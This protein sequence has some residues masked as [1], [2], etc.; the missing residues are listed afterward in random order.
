MIRGKDP[1]SQQHRNNSIK[2]WEQIHRDNARE[3]IRTDDWL[4]DFDEI[5]LK[6]ERPILDLGCGSGND[7]LY[8]LNKGKQVIACDQSENAIGCIRRDFPEITEARCFNMLDGLPFENESF[9]IVIA[10]LCLHYFGG[11]DTLFVISEIGRI[12][13]PGGHLFL[14]VNSVNDKNHG[15]GRGKEIER[16]VYETEAGTIKRFF[17]EEDIRYYFGSFELRYLKEETMDRYRLKKRLF[18]VC[19]RKPAV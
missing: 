8:L 15:A 1:M 18:R 6:A 11:E 3:K 10:D 14:R 5:I 19:A 16:H 13:I 7:T 17:D 12:L 9:E 2:Y 4:E